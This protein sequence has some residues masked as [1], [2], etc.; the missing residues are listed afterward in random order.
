MSSYCSSSTC[1][2][3]NCPGCRNGSK[4][5]NDPR[6][7]P[8]CPDCSSETSISCV[9]KRSTWDWIL[10]IVV[11]VLAIVLL[12]L[13]AWGLYSSG[14]DDDADD[15]MNQSEQSNQN[16]QPDNQ[17]GYQ[18][19]NYQPE[20]QSTYRPYNSEIDATLDVDIVG[21]NVP[22]TTMLPDLPE[23]NFNATPSVGMAQLPPP[24]P[25]SLRNDSRIRGF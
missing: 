21:D 6:C 24:R 17:Q 16:Y 22:M 7:Y 1:L 10:L 13:I 25:A 2:N 8:D 3:G 12:V 20:Y 11:T 19:S 23:M 18:P 15:Q 5:C 14:D 9:K 4:Y